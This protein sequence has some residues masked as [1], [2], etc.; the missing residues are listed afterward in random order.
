MIDVHLGAR[1]HQGLSLTGRIHLPA[2]PLHA[3]AQLGQRR[4]AHHHLAAGN[5]RDH[6]AGDV[7]IRRP[8]TAADKDHVHTAKRITDGRFHGREV[9]GHRGVAIEDNAKTTQCPS[10]LLRMRVHR[11]TA[12]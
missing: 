9:V 12:Q 5:L 6:I 8:Q 7:I 10:Q 4:F 2:G 11:P 1:D 3:S